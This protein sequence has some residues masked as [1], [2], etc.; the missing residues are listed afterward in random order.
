MGAWGHRNFENDSAMD[1]VGDFLE[2]PTET[3]LSD[4]LAIVIDASAEEQY[5]E[6]EEASAALAAAEMVAAAN[7]R[8]SSDFPQE[9]SALLKK[10]GF[11]PNE[12]LMKKARKAVSVVLKESE[13]Q[14]LWA[15]S[16]EPNEWQD[17]QT[18][19]L[20]RLSK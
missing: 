9:L 6:V 17:V 4:A 13:L 5:I 12:K 2:S 7:G 10:T 8:G 11:V 3:A 1:F 14:E 15:E 16:G 19:L 18:D 20:A